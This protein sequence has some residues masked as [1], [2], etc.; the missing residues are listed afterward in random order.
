MTYSAIFT[1]LGHRVTYFLVMGLGG[2]IGAVFLF[3]DNEDRTMRSTYK[4]TTCKIEQAEVTVD[5]H[6]TG[7]RRNRHI[8]RTYYP[9][10]VY[11]YSVNGEEYQSD[12]YRFY[13]MGMTETEATTVVGR[14][15]EGGSASCYYDPAN[16][17]DAVLTLDSDR[18]GMYTLAGFGLLLLLAGLAGWIV[19]DFI[20]PAA[21]KASKPP[22]QDL[23]VQVPEWSA[24]ARTS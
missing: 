14:Y 24:Q 19:L 18:S 7:G 4:Q 22:Q 10:I 6:L 12:M 8:S 21:D 23:T 5:E 2:L 13:E 17:E 20:L 9:E 3:W 15:T 11:S 16:P 1:L